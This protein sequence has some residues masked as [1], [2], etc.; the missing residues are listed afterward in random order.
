M[1]VTRSDIARSVAGELGLS[2]RLVL[3]ILN[4][5]TEEISEAVAGGERVE[6]R[7]FGVFSRRELGKRV[8]R[9][10]KSGRNMHVPARTALKFKPG[11]NLKNTL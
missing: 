5:F 8:I 11:K 2:R 3:K 9:N 7:N 4:A 10:P 6:L 1:T